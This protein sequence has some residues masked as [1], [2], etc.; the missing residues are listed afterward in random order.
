MV[1]MVKIIYACKHVL[2][3][4]LPAIIQICVYRFV[5]M[6]LFLKAEVV[7]LLAHLALMLIQIPISAPH[8]VVEDYME[9][10][11]QILALLHVNLI[12]IKILQVIAKIAAILF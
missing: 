12:T 11:H 4:E 3:L 10:Q 6:E 2:P 8:L 7:K 9:I 5:P 1:G